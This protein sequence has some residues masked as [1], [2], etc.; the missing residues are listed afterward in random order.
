MKPLLPLLLLLCSTAFAQKLVT[1]K[2]DEFTGKY[3]KETSVEIL[4]HPFKMSGYSYDFRFKSVDTDIYLNLKI[5]SISNSVFAIKDGNVLMLK[6]G[7][8]SILKL[9]NSEYTISQQ[10]KGASGIV[11]SACQGVSLYFLL[12]KEDIH[13]IKNTK[14]VKVRLYTTGGYSEQDVKAVADKRVK[15][16]LKLVL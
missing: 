1:D 5:M 7:N 4:S 15:D 13:V 12:S 11:G 8:D 9:S 2:K 3:V 10:G 6:M 14:I 16:A